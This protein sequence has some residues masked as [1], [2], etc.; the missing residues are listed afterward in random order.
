MNVIDLT[1]EYIKHILN[2]GDLASYE[3]SYPALFRHYFKYAAKR[4][5]FSKTLTI[6]EV[7]KR[8]SL[9]LPR[10]SRIEKKFDKFGCDISSLK[11]V[12]FVGQRTSNGHAFKD[13]E[14]FVVWIPIETY[15]TPSLVDVFIPHEIIHALHY[16][17]SPDFYFNNKGKQR[18][19]SR[20]LITEGIATYFTKLIMKFSQSEAL[21]ADYLSKEKIKSWLSECRKKEKELYKFVLKNFYS[22]NSKISIFYAKNPKNIYEFRAG[23]YVGFKLVDRIVK[24]HKLEPKKLLVIPRE[25]FEDLILEKLK[26]S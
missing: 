18:M 12:L 8:L 3:R 7:K 17:Q 6:S 10:L 21:W 23:Y 14:E 25:E 9:I 26:M 11:M 13:K 5:N 22:S 20:Q 4:K 1:P 24:N 19:V 2:A 15:T 16:S